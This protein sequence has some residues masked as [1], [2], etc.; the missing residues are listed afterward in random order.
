M[1][2]YGP[3]AIYLVRSGCRGAAVSTVFPGSLGGR[4]RIRRSPRPTNAGSNRPPMVRGASRCASIL[5]AMLFVIFDVEAASFYPWAVQ[6]HQLRTF[7]LIEMV[8]FVSCSRSATRTCGG[9][10]VSYGGERARPV[11][12]GQAGRRRALGAIVERVAADDGVGVLR[13]RDDDRHRGGVRHRA[14]RF[15]SLS[16]V[17]APGRSDDRFGPRGAEDGAGGAPV[18]NKWPIPSG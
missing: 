11:F 9:G 18:R 3:V 17:A 7:G 1:N 5:I 2:P 4:S 12:P 13:D 6:M 15:G 16:R 8:S 10:E 14:L